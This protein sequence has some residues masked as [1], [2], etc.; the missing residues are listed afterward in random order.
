[1]CAGARDS[2]SNEARRRQFMEI[3]ME[4]HL[5][6]PSNRDYVDLENAADVEWWCRLLGISEDELRRTVQDVGSDARAV[7]E[8]SRK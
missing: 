8:H 4:K 5:D 1:M 6:G 2:Y 7:R 3:N